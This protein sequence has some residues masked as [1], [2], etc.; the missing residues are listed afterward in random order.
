MKKVIQKRLFVFLLIGLYF[1]SLCIRGENTPICGKN[2]E[3]GKSGSAGNADLE[4]KGEEEHSSSG[5]TDI[6]PEYL[7]RLA[8]EEK[9]AVFTFPERKKRYFYHGLREGNLVALTF[10]DGPNPVY[11]PK[12]LAFLKKKNVRATFFITGE[13]ARLYPQIVREIVQCGCEVGNH[14]YSHP[15]FRKISPEKIKEELVKTQTEI[16][17]ACNASPGVVRFPYGVSSQDA[18]RLA[19]EM[20]LD[21]FFWSIDTNDYKKSVTSE[22]IINSV[23]SKTKGGSIILMHD[24]SQKVVDAVGEIID[25]LLKKGY[26]FAT[27]SELSEQ[28]RMDEYMK[29]KKRDVPE[30]LQDSSKRR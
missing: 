20:Y 3:T 8:F 1:I 23:L 24:K 30:S 6:T 25:P 10:D 22:D 7:R 17:K 29:K 12:L 13:N 14:S 16:K 4:K 28:I 11:T 19:F 26:K 18:A 21:P 2:K 5:A 9:D 15:N 27:C